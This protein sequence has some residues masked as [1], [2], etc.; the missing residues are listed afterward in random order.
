M[1]LVADR[2]QLQPILIRR[3]A[4]CPPLTQRRRTTEGR[5][6]RRDGAEVCK[7]GGEPSMDHNRTEIETGLMKRGEAERQTRR[8]QESRPSKY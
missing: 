5:E 8:E 7:V 3:S 1:G 6:T 4:R 2:F